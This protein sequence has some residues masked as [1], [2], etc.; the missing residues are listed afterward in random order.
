MKYFLLS[1]FFLNCAIGQ[2][3]F[4]IVKTGTA[5]TLEG[6]IHSEGKFLKTLTV[7]HS[8][9]IIKNNDKY[10]LFDTGLGNQ[11]H[12][13][14]Q[15]DMPL[16]A[17][18]LFKY[19]FSKSI[20]EQVGEKISISG[21][22]LSHVHWD[23]AS[24][25]NDFD[26]VITYISNDEK[27]ELVDLVRNR[28]FPSQFSGSTLE[29][30]SWSSRQVEMFTKTYD[31]FNDGK[32]ILVPLSGHSYG[33]IGLILYADDTKY[34]FVGDAIWTHLQL[35]YQSQKFYISSCL[36]DRDKE[37]TFKTQLIIKEMQNRGFEIIPTH[38]SIIQDKL[39]YYPRW[40][41]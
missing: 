11:I 41:K 8:G 14:F 9:F 37:Q 36:V 24:G 5:K 22:Y 1:M 34:F 15:L 7:N 40:I 30:F 19:N 25:I 26:N 6:L 23:H 16:W 33:S 4:S 13:Q 10:I 3:E 18:P 17:Q 20:K 38:D 2:V 28:T 35:K 29:T 31:I 32:A 12:N 27:K 21:I 39:G